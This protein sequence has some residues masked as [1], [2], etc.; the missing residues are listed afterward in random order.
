MRIE[1]IIAGAVHR[2]FIEKSLPEPDS[3]LIQLQKTRREFVGDITLVVFPLSRFIKKTPQEAAEVLG[4]YLKELKEIDDFNVVKGFLN[5]VVEPSYWIGFVNRYHTDNNYGLPEAPL[6]KE[7]VLVEFSSPNTNKPLHLGHVRN[8]LLGISISRIL[9]ANGKN[10][11][12]VNLV[13][14]RGIHI[15]K[16]MLAWQ[17]WGENRTPEDAGV[18]G[19]HYVG[20]LYVK[21]ETAYRAEIQEL[22]EKGMGEEEARKE[23]SLI[24]EA[25]EM[26]RKWE[27]DD[28]AVTYLWKMMNGWV[29]E[30]FDVTYERMG[31]TFDRIYYESETYHTGKS[32]VEEGL[33]NSILKRKK[34]GSVWADL[35]HRG[36]DE[37]LLLRSD[38]TSVYITQDLGTAVLRQAD[39]NADRMYYVV[40]NEQD[41]HFKVL[42][43][44]L[45]ELGYKWAGSLEHISYGMVELPSGKMKS[46]EGKV[47]DADNLIDEM[48]QTAGRL[49]AELGKLDGLADKEREDIIK[50]IGMGALKYFILKVD[51]KKNMIFNPEESIDFNGNT[52]PFIQY[53]HARI[54]SLLKNAF[55]L[56]IIVTDTL[57]NG[58]PL[59]EKETRLAVLLHEYPEVVTE[60]GNNCSPAL[61]ANYVFEL[62][63]E[64]NQ[65]YHDH[66]VIKEPDMVVREFRLKL[67]GMT[68]MVIKNSME[69]LG[70]TVPEKM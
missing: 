37:K 54:C 53:T 33:K 34:D 62:A 24:K 10:V 52:G 46:R 64:F 58:F 7:T 60:S 50:T 5:L 1:S 2:F 51:P 55:Q 65:F 70:I 36:L 42:S 23:A 48:I 9:E 56:G 29:Y 13:N 38:G 57:K 14:D 63:K 19:D 28:P 39:Y 43:L 59:S 44:I 27:A 45:D 40:G 35:T 8:N 25:Q 4:I 66:P 20:D 11:K 15:C 67:T 31:V 49:S 17:K 68:G 22:V 47:V 30:G 69:L 61:I 18:K 12:K 41:Y 26:L 21:F 3:S 32:I 16:T 6:D